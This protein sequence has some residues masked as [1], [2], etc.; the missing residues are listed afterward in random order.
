VSS[1][2]SVVNM[3]RDENAREGGVLKE[4]FVATIKHLIVNVGKHEV[5]KPG[6]NFAGSEL[7]SIIGDRIG[8]YISVKAEDEKQKKAE[9]AKNK[10]SVEE[11]KGNEI[12]IQKTAANKGKGA[13]KKPNSIEN[14]LKLQKES[15][16][17]KNE[18]DLSRNSC[19]V[20]YN[21]ENQCRFDQEAALKALQRLY[22][23]ASPEVQRQIAEDYAR[24]HNLDSGALEQTTVDFEIVLT[25]VTGGFASGFVVKTL[26][27]FGS[28]FLTGEA[29]DSVNDYLHYSHGYAR[30]KD[31]EK[32]IKFGKFE[33]VYDPEKI[34]RQGLREFHS[35]SPGGIEGARRLFEKFTGRRPIGDRDQHIFGGN[36]YDSIQYREKGSRSDHPKIDISNPAQKSLEKITFK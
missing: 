26:S 27:K 32:F 1:C 35:E 2:N 6:A 29:V 19:P 22:L 23:N 15:N 21:N 20:N 3:M 34:T 31:G 16:Q 30:L 14:K 36:K 8:S 24:T 10:N 25:L 17:Y 28:K 4:K 18:N 13:D 7:G 5:V 12:G 33:K 11:D 9:K